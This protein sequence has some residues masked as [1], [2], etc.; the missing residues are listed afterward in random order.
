MIDHL[1]CRNECH[2]HDECADDT[3][4]GKDRELPHGLD[5]GYRVR[6]KGDTSGECGEKEGCS[7]REGGESQGIR[8]GLSV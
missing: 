1:G 8:N 3:Y 5:L 7:N 4:Q 2:H 6:T